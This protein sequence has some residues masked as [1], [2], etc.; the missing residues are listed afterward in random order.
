MAFGA[1]GK[2][3]PMIAR[4]ALWV[5]ALFFSQWQRA[6]PWMLK[7]M[8]LRRG[9]IWLFVVLRLVT[10]EGVDIGLIG[11]CLALFQVLG[12]M[13]AGVAQSFTVLQVHG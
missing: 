8:R 2:E 9:E 5:H 10:E 7:R 11:L 6:G 3:W 4:G 12:R 13:R 1:A